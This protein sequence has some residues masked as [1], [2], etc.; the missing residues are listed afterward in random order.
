MLQTLLIESTNGII[1]KYGLDP[2]WQ[3]TVTTLTPAGID[4]A[5]M[6]KANTALSNT[7]EI[8]N[9]ALEKGQQMPDSPEKTQFLN[10]LKTIGQALNALQ[11]SIYSMQSAQSDKASVFSHARLSSQLEDAAKQQAAADKTKHAQGKMGNSGPLSQIMDWITKSIILVVGLCTAPVGLAMAVFYV[12]DSAKSEKDG[13]TPL[14]QQMFADISEKIGGGKAGSAGSAFI[15][16]MLATTLS[17]VSCNPFLAMNLI[18]QDSKS[19]Q[20]FIKAGGGD[21]AQQAL[22]A[23]VVMMAVQ[24]AVMVAMSVG[25]MGFGTSAALADA[26]Q[27]LAKIADIS[28]KTA[29]TIV[30]ASFMAVQATVLSLQVANSAVQINNNTWLSRIDRYKGDSESFSEEIQAT[31]TV[32]KKLADKLLAMLQGNSDMIV[33]INTAQGK[34]WSD[35]SSISSEI[36]G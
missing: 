36:M 9:R 20:G 15:N 5:L 3:P 6:N 2:T 30:K 11:E 27:S 28:V 19:V 14:V 29:T 7:Q 33:N 34:K 4:P 35:V 16:M 10:Y 13:S 18:L 12:A 22:G 26:A 25:T 23:A 1:G 32:L 8:Y 21:D 31:I 17:L 24:M